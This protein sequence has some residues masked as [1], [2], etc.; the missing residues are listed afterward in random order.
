MFHAAAP[1]ASRLC[2]QHHGCGPR[3]KDSTPRTQHAPPVLCNRP[4]GRIP[5]HSGLHKDLTD[6]NTCSN[7]RTGP[8]AGNYA[9]PQPWCTAAGSG[10][11]ASRP[12]SHACS[13]STRAHDAALHCHA[14]IYTANKYQSCLKRTN[15]P[16][17]PPR[18]YGRHRRS[19]ISAA[20]R[21]TGCSGDAD[22]IVY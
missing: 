19:R 6:R 1:P 13:H 21:V 5:R 11:A 18:T 22:N 7:S 17:A 14:C 15:A 16:P 8:Y 10:R 20:H 9:R 3:R 4:H 12:P 2:A